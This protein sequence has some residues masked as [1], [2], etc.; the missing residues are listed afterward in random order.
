MPR[1]KNAIPRM[2]LHKATGQ[3][4]V[5]IDGKD[6]YLGTH[7]KD[8]TLIRYRRMI[9]D[10]AYEEAH[11]AIV[12]HIA[13][14]ESIKDSLEQ[15]V[16]DAQQKIRTAEKELELLRWKAESYMLS[17]P[18]LPKPPKPFGELGVVDMPSR[19]GV[20]FLHNSHGI[21]YVGKT[22]DLRHRFGVWG[23]RHHAARVNDEISWIE[24]DEDQLHF[25]ECY[26]I[27]LIK[28]IR[29]FGND[30]SL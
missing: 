14:L 20:Y 3:A 27:W 28:P 8:E 12:S 9:G 15:Q 22:V 4:V 10:L 21:E 25:L 26:Y 19:S 16:C 11:K 18:K 13:D 30:K 23:E 7:G 29:N 24:F 6:F 5:T 2:R 1:Q 17:D